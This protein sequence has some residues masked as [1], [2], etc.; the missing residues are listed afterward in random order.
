MRF[1]TLLRLKS[2]IGL[3][4]L[5]FNANLIF[6]QETVRDEF[7]LRRYDNNDGTQNWSTNWIES[8]DSNGAT[9]GRI[10]VNGSRLRFEDISRN[11]QWVK[12]TFNLNSV[13]ATSAS[14]RFNW[15]TVRLDQSGGSGEELNVQVSSALNGPFVT[16]GSF[17][18]TQNGVFNLDISAY[19]S[20]NT[21][22]RFINTNTLSWGDW[23]PNE[24]VFIDNLEISY[25][26]DA[27]LSPCANGSD[28]IWT[29]NFEGINQGWS[30]SNN[31]QGTIGVRNYPQNGSGGSGLVATDVDNVAIWTSNTI[32]ISDYK[33]VKVNMDIGSWFDSGGN[34]LETNDYIEVL[35]SLDGA[36][37]VRFQSNPYFTD[38]VIPVKSCAG[39]FNGSSLVL[40][41]RMRNTYT[42]EHHYIDNIV[43]SGTSTSSAPPVI[44]ASGDQSFCTGDPQISVVESISITDPDVTD[45]TLEEMSI[46]ISG[47]YVSGEDVL[48]LSGSQ[49][50]ISSSWDVSS[51]K[52]TLT[53]PATFAEFEAAISAV[54]YSNSNASPSLGERT[55]TITLQQANFLAQTGHFYEFV[56]DV[57]IRWDDARD[58]AA[59]RSYYGLQGYLATLTSQEESDLAG[60]QINGAGWIG[61]SDAAVEGEWRWVTG[62]ESGTVFWNGTAGGSSPNWAFWNTGEPNQA[63]NE[64]YA[65]ITDPTVGIDGSWNDLSITGADSGVYQPKGYIVEYGGMAGDPTLQ[66]SASTK[67][68]V[69]TIP[70]PFGIYHE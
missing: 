13:G 29:E 44:T 67:I 66:I 43:V 55:F 2:F 51:G 41:V 25:S 70:V 9:G 49:A 11:S 65:H 17:K 50:N 60:S 14:L 22:V 35:Y 21:T 27:T 64:D 57:G 47:G 8:N 32:N 52:I 37:F 1:S 16:I 28:N 56:P 10:Q 48:S 6:A 26:T 7:G 36:G 61:A 34:S 30:V 46:Q 39:V 59:L 19:I 18:G 63:G 5:L 42:D 54:M 58:A 24:Y 40:R 33:D 53:G 23:E 4:Y 3:A 62:P 38:D 15:E 20:S 69:N 68:T 45:T 12:R 31:G